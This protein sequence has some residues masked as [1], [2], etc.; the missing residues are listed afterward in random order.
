MSA[1]TADTRPPRRVNR[2]L[3]A[4]AAGAAIAVLAFAGAASACWT[5]AWN[6][7]GN[8]QVGSTVN[9]ATLLPTNQWISPYGTRILDTTERLVSSSVSPNGEYLAALG[10]NDFQGNLTIFNLQTGTMVQSTQLNN[11]S[12]YGGY[13][14]DTSVGA[15][16]TAVVGRTARR[17][18]S[19]SRRSC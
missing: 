15:R 11:G 18:G 7:F 6:P 12:W 16:R 5:G 4:V 1:F 9:G 10:W 14:S 8:A 19:R 17:S 13:D 2:R 3:R